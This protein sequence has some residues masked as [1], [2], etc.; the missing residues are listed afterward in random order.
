MP[1]DAVFARD[2]L[3][4]A[5]ATERSG[6]AF[7]TRAARLSRDP[8]GRK[9]F[10]KL[11]TEEVD[12]LDEA[13]GAL[14]RAPRRR[15]GAR[16][17]ADVPL[18]QGRG[19]RPVRRGHRRA[20]E[21]RRGQSQALLIGIRCERGSHKFFK[22]YGERFEESEGKRIFLEFADEEREHLELL[23]REYRALLGAPAQAAE[24]RRRQ[25]PRDRSPPA[26]D[27]VRRPIDARGARARSRGRRRATR[28]PSP[29]T[30]RWRRRPPSRRRPRA[31]GPGLDLPASR[32]R[33]SAT[34][35]TS[36]CSATFSIPIDDELDAFLTA[37]RADRAPA[38]RDDG[39]DARDAGRADRRGALLE[40]SAVAV[41]PAS[42][43]AGRSWPVPSSRPDTRTTSPTRSID[44]SP[45]AGPRSSSG[46][47]RPRP[48]WSR[49]I[50]RAGGLAVARA[51]GQA[52]ARRPR[53]G[54][55][56]RRGMRA[57]EVHHP[58]HD[59]ADVAHYAQIAHTHGLAVT[60]GSDYHG[61][62]SGRTS[63]AG[64][65]RADR[66]SSSRG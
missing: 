55:R 66:R 61:P 23:I 36:T 65:R 59:A 52:R 7:Y 17:A 9:I 11:A 41:A 13:R 22:R 33:R 38:P 54:D 50:A 48:T 34:A 2:A 10:E 32:S 43:S 12:H 29:I 64:P 35:A 18:L 25:A 21:S 20:D 30:T 31:R 49:L 4:M 26:H 44:S 56:S 42:R 27:G 46:A 39:R 47:V 57:I 28:S 51:P 24:R 19:Q 3:R 63:G 53:V 60:G 8:R 37:Q 15:S 45:R 58:D 5:I 1:T 16:I 14:P 62:G 6:L 40:R